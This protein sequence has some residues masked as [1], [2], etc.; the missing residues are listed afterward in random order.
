M[1]SIIL[2]V[3][4]GEKY[5]RLALESIKTQTNDDFE[6]IIVNDCSTD[7]TPQIAEEYVKKDKRFC[8]INNDK[9]L[10]LP[11]SLNVGFKAAK[12]DLLTWTSDDNIL[13][14]NMLEKLCAK[15]NEGYEFVY[16]NMDYIGS[17][18]ELL[19]NESRIGEDIWYSNY[20]GACFM[21]TRRAYDTVGEYDTEAFLVEDY[22]Y[23]LR[24]ASRF[25]LGFIDE[26]LYGYRLH[27][28]SLTG[29]RQID[30]AKKRLEL[31]YKY[32]NDN[33]IDEKIKNKIRVQMADTYYSLNN[34]EELRKILGC[35]KQNDKNEYYKTRKSTRLN[36]YIPKVFIEIIR[37]IKK[38]L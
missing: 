33:S 25:K 5:L 15:I 19:K 26:K 12:G 17:E 36:Y 31:L 2:P 8:L 11:A 35:L 34:R 13:Y 7:S 37:K 16:A 32:I 29:S 1:I 22:D 38:G 30:I 3:Y 10:R 20:V 27:D 23:W 28:N 18:G 4:N 14:P 21:Y 9:N 6:V 24:I